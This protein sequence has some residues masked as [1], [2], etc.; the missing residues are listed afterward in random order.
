[1]FDVTLATGEDYRESQFVR[2]GA[3]AV[4]CATPW[5]ALGATVCYDVRFP[6]LYRTLAHAGATL[7]TVPAAFTRATGEAHWHTLLRARSIENG[8]FVLAAAQCGEHAGGRKT[9]GHSLAVDPWGRVLADAG[10]DAVG[11]TMV[12][13]SL[14]EVRRARQQVPSL[15]HDRDF[16]LRVAGGDVH[17]SAAA[18]DA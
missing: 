4:L 5:G 13:L 11:V 2:P 1:M 3:E 9:Y 12:T 14:D 6:H 18:P 17:A 7:F 15:Q 8:C 16:T 10:P